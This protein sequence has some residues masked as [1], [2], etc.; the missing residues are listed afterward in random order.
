MAS[1]TAWPQ[2][3]FSLCDQACSQLPVSYLKEIITNFKG[4]RGINFFSMFLI[5]LVVSKQKPK[6]D[7]AAVEH[8]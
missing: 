2:S 4:G 7:V 6:R 1:D 8:K 5:D 3:E